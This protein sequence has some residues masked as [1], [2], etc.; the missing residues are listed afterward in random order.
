MKRATSA[1]Y[2]TC[3]AHYNSSDTSRILSVTDGARSANVVMLGNYIVGERTL[4]VSGR[5]GVL[6]P[7]FAAPACTALEHHS[8]PSSVDRGP[9]DER[10]NSRDLLSR[11]FFRWNIR[12]RPY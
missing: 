5:K 2:G 7:E 1:R 3:V 6:P 8:A 4:G 12:N 11:L 9:S 10:L